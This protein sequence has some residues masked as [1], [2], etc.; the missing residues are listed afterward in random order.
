[1]PA[2]S[3]TMPIHPKSPSAA[4]QRRWTSTLHPQPASFP[5]IARPMPR[6]AAVTNAVGPGEGA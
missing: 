1:M 4:L 5:E 2:L 3:T 6:E